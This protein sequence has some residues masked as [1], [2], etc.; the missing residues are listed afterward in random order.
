M[1]P[2]WMVANAGLR[3]E[4]RDEADA[5]GRQHTLQIR[6]KRGSPSGGS[7][8]DDSSEDDAN[9][10]S[11]EDLGEPGAG[12]ISETTI[13]RSEDDDGDDDG[14]NDMDGPRCK[15]SAASA[16]AR[17]G[18]GRRSNDDGSDD[19]DSIP[20]AT[21]SQRVIAAALARLREAR[22]SV[23]LCPERGVFY[24][25]RLA[26]EID[27][28]AA[29]EREAGE[30]ETTVAD[31][32]KRG[33]VDAPSRDVLAAVAEP[34]FWPLHVAAAAAGLPSPESL[35]RSGMISQPEL[36]HMRASDDEVC[37][38]GPLRMLT[39]TGIVNVRDFSGVPYCV[40]CDQYD[41]WRSRHS[42]RSGWCAEIAGD[43]DASGPVGFAVAKL[44]D[45]PG[46]EMGKE[47]FDM[48]QVKPYRRLPFAFAGAEYA[49][50]VGQ[51]VAL[52]TQLSSD[53]LERFLLVA[54]VW[55]GPVSAAIMLSP[56]KPAEDMAAVLAAV[57]DPDHAEVL[58]RT[59]LHLVRDYHAGEDPV[60]HGQRRVPYPINTLR[61]EALR[62]LCAPTYDHHQL[63]QYQSNGDDDH[64]RDD[65]EAV[66]PPPV[67]AAIAAT[68]LQSPAP[69]FLIDADFLPSRGLEA[70]VRRTLERW[71][72]ELGPTVAARRALVVP[73]FDL[74]D[75]EADAIPREREEMIASLHRGCSTIASSTIQADAASHGAT[76]VLEWTKEP[77]GVAIENTFVCLHGCFVFCF[78]FFFELQVINCFFCLFYKHLLA[79]QT[80]TGF[81][82]SAGS[83]PTMS[84]WRRRTDT[85]KSTA[86]GVQTSRCTRICSMPP[87]LNFTF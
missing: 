87:G 70:M 73:A 85:M 49:A 80:G 21:A 29:L 81:D 86:A 69:L 78:V 63:N 53:R 39:D 2:P 5:L 12:D 84:C 43:N 59:A 65:E 1:P 24:S 23:A 45:E 20:G 62:R 51:Q 15:R 13:D 83:N 3:R 76:N 40:A 31:V 28:D 10:W 55:D 71:S 52:A 19:D 75:A 4:L 37:T 9:C 72:S 54:A 44:E 14:D 17:R 47:L 82:S 50:I 60:H 16:T 79:T 18:R 56:D 61:N 46:M 68:A 32:L 33:V 38:S 42:G 66:A 34:A 36:H 58:R 8:A 35:V 74:C 41:S 25:A 7:G 57:A 67:G 26:A 64:P 6:P 30:V 11:I 77:D 27:A 22:V 48:R